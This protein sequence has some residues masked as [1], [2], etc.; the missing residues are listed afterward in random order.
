MG[1]VCS[2]YAGVVVPRYRIATDIYRGVALD[3]QAILAVPMYLIVQ[4]RCSRVL[5]RRYPIHQVA[6][7]P[8]ILDGGK[9]A[10]LHLDARYERV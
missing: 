1:V 5:V 8:V 7:Y 4:N 10:L 3:V 6:E 2:D 9:G